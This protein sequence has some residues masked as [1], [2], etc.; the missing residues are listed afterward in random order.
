MEITFYLI[1]YLFV[2]LPHTGPA[3][4]VVLTLVRKQQ[5]AARREYAAKVVRFIL[6]IEEL[7]I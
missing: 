5:R 3:V 4:T 2:F 7:P 6:Q 1:F